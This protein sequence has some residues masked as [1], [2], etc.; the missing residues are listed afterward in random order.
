MRPWLW[1]IESTTSSYNM[2]LFPAWLVIASTGASCALLASL[3]V[4][5]IAPA[6]TGAGVAL[7]MAGG[8]FRASF[9]PT[10]NRRT[11]SARLYNHLSIHREG[12]PF[13][14]C[15]ELGSSAGSQ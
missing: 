11:E 7:V 4:I 1:V 3:L 12:K 13:K 5:Y 14:S 15:S 9:R 8:L 2:N 6:A 10:L